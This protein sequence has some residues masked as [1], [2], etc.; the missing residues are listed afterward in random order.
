MINFCLA[1][2]VGVLLT[3]HLKVP[4]KLFQMVRTA[5]E[6]FDAQIYQKESCR[7]D[8]DGTN[9]RKFS[10]S[11]QQEI[12]CYFERIDFGTVETR[13]FW[14]KSVCLLLNH[15]HGTLNSSGDQQCDFQ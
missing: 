5:Q 15:V 9:T 12:P 6:E 3:A 11:F 2:L 14:P 13:G 10:F 8:F 1:V 7:S 4:F